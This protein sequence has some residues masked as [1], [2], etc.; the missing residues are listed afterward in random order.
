MADAGPA[1]R[2]TAAAV[3]GAS[4]ATRAPR[5]LRWT[6]CSAGMDMTGVSLGRCRASPGE[7]PTPPRPDCGPAAAELRWGCGGGLARPHPR[8]WRT[9]GL[10][11]EQRLGSA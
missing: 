6:V 8:Y 7:G 5:W 9:H 1:P 4:S 2:T 10:H 11:L 3:N